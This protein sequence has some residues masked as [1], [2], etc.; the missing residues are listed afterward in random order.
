MAKGWGSRRVE[1][2]EERS[3]AITFTNAQVLT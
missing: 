3:E 2:E 1:G